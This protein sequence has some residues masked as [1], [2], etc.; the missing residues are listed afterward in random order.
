TLVVGLVPSA[1]FREEAMAI[2]PTVVVVASL[3]IALVVLAWPFLNVALQ[4]AR[5]PLTYFDGL[6]LGFSATAGLAIATILAVT[7]M[8]CAR[9]ERDLD[10]QLALLAE[11]LDQE[12]AAEIAA[13]AEALARFAGWLS[14]C[15]NRRWDDVAYNIQGACRA[16]S[17]GAPPESRDF[18]FVA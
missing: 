10:G 15:P 17:A 14:Q 2:S 12:L 7:S 18:T 6:Q 11:E 9:L 3:L 4:S 13:S 8:Q 16:G 5:K 1:A